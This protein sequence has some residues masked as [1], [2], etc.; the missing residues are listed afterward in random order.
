MSPS[1]STTGEPE[2]SDTVAVPGVGEARRHVR[3]TLAPAG[4]QTGGQH[5]RR[6]GDQDRAGRWEAG[7]RL[8]QVAAGA[9]DDDVE[10]ATEPRLGLDLT[11]DWL[12]KWRD[13]IPDRLAV[14]AAPTCG[15]RRRR[16]G[17]RASGRLHCPK[18]L[19]EWHWATVDAR[20]W[21]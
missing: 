20:A 9:V 21:P 3:R 6:R 4:A 8:G 17:A 12:V 15:T 1:L 16:R 14:A 18:P 10:P 2:G 11:V 7:T 13:L 19:Y 5:V